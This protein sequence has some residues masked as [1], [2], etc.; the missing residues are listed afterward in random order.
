VHERHIRDDVASAENSGARGTPTFFVGERRHMGA[1]DATT[2]A[3]E[4]EDLREAP[5]TTPAGSR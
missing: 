1:Y 4:L 5:V 2:L 3:N